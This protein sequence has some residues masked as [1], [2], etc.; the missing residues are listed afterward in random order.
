MS[1]PEFGNGE[2]TGLRATLV[3]AGYDPLDGLAATPRTY[4]TDPCPTT[5]AQGPS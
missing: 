2:P 4:Q 5:D 3:R 1:R